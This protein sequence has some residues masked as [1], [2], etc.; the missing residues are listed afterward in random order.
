[1]A[2]RGGGPYKLLFGL[3]S[4]LFLGILVFVFVVVR[5][6]PPVLLDEQGHRQGAP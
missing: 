1:M 3:M 5:R 6:A 2:P 4:A